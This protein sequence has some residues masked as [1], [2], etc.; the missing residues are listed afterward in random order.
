[1]CT[2]ELHRKVHLVF[3]EGMSRRQAA[4]HFNMSRDRV[5]KMLESG[6]AST[7][8]SCPETG[9]ISSRQDKARA[10]QGLVAD[11]PEGEADQDWRQDHQPWPLSR[12]PDGRGRY[13]ET[14]LRRHPAAD[15][16]TSAAT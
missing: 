6:P 8:R 10:D 3:A 16:R 2:E 5:R 15:R 7:P 14:P 4:R 11:Q 9:Q 1:M 12:L 13:P